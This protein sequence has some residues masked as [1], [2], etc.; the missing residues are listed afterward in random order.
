VS[1]RSR[2][3]PK[4]SLQ[5]GTDGEFTRWV[6]VTL[7]VDGCICTARPPVSV[8]HGLTAEVVAGGAAWRAEHGGALLFGTEGVGQ[9]V[10]RSAGKGPLV[11]AERLLLLWTE[12]VRTEPLEGWP[13]GFARVTGDGQVW[14]WAPGFVQQLPLYRLPTSMLV[15]L[16][17]VV[18]AETGPAAPVPVDGPDGRPMLRIDAR[19]KAL[20]HS[21]PFPGSA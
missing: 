13:A 20:V 15:G 14:L 8:S 1:R 4:V 21:C 3:K 11:V 19:A 2:E 5:T 17:Q 12:D 6:E 10:P 7:P 16:E 18:W 9:V